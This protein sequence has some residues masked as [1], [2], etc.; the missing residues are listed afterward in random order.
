VRLGVDRNIS[1]ACTRRTYCLRKKFQ[2][3]QVTQITADI[4]LLDNL[5]A[6]WA[7]STSNPSTNAQCRR[8]FCRPGFDRRSGA[9]SATP[10]EANA[11]A[12]QAY[13]AIQALPHRTIFSA[14]FK[15]R[16]ARVSTDLVQTRLLL[17][18]ENVIPAAFLAILVL[19]LVI[20]FA[21]FSL[22]S[23]LTVSACHRSSHCWH[24]AQFS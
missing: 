13:L 17:E 2:S 18:S 10:F 8:R 22:L 7:G 12:E 16:A 9:S 11:S 3:N 14:H 23:P 20:I 5:L 19:C 15:G 21:S 24:Q 4:I 1:R 6:V